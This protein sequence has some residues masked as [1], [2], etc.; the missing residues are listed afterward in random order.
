MDEII[1]GT[2]INESKNRF[3]CVVKLTSGE[4]EE[5]YVP[6]SCRISNFLDM[7]NATVYLRKNKDSTARTKYR[8]IAVETSTGIIPLEMT[9][10]N[11][12]VEEN[13]RN[14]RF[15][16]IGK[17]NEVLRE[18]KIEN[19]K[20]DLFIPKTKTIIEIKSVL[21]FDNNAT[22]PTVYSERANS[23]LKQ[24]EQLLDDGY[25]VVYIFISLTPKP[26]EIK[27]NKSI[28]E[29]YKPFKNC[30]DKGMLVYGC[31]IKMDNL[32]IRAGRRIKIVL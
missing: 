23:Q 11:R 7:S 17:R 29:Y 13:I 6:S 12:F 5:C 14:R 1:K 25:R 10:A 24:F 15:S 8:L 19:Y 2:F 9:Y 3:L 28:G 22:F 31:S 18:H 4:E 20:C 16:F 26:K 27:I 32:Q 21:S 30:V